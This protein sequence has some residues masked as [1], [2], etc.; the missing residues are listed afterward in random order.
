MA[1]K[2]ITSF[3]MPSAWTIDDSYERWRTGCAHGAVAARALS[4]FF[5]TQLLPP[6]SGMSQPSGCCAP[7]MR[8][9]TR[10]YRMHRN[11]ALPCKAES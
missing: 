3:L 1:S 10:G 6:Y 9:I 5:P 8:R 7:W 2:S 4:V 11:A